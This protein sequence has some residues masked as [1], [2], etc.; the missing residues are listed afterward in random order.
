MWQTI[1]FYS[2]LVLL[3]YIVVFKIILRK[4][5]LKNDIS[6]NLGNYTTS[7]VLVGAANG[8]IAKQKSRINRLI[9]EYHNIEIVIPETILAINPSYLEK[10]L[11]D[12]IYE[13][14]EEEI[15]K[16]IIFRCE[17]KCE[18]DKTLEE[19]ISRIKIRKQYA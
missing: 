14:N 19:V 6:I 2:V 8:E 16:R 9:K 13:L 11:Y 7:N 1:L 4:L 18:I 10:F 5:K 12:I 17:G 3:I 15:R